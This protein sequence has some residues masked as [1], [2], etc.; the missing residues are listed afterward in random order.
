MD[1]KCISCHEPLSYPSGDGCANMT[2]H[3]Q[4]EHIKDD[5]KK[6]DM[7]VVSVVEHEDGSATYTFDMTDAMSA[8]CHSEGLKLLMYCGAFGLSTSA[9]YGMIAKAGELNE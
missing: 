6:F 9:V 4:E 5:K 3:T 7:E 8:V 2:A 1:D